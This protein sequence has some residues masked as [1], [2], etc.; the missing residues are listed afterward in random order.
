M[1]TFTMNV[2]AK[3]STWQKAQP[4]FHSK[5]FI[6][7][8]PSGQW[9]HTRDIY[10]NHRG[11]GKTAGAVYMMPGADEMCLLVKIIDGTDIKLMHFTGIDVIE[12]R[13]NNDNSEVYFVA[14]DEPHPRKASGGYND[15]SGFLTVR[16][17]INSV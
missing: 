12:Y 14:N 5:E 6:R 15:N 4:S 10:C 11:R 13:F 16:I 3:T 7:I 1:A 8:I 17:E 9:F 2:D